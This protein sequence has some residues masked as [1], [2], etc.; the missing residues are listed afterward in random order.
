M[1]EIENYRRNEDILLAEL[2]RIRDMADARRSELLDQRLLTRL[3]ESGEVGVTARIIEAPTLPEGAVWPKP[4]LVLAG[5]AILGLMGGFFMALV[6]L[7]RS[8]GQWV[9]SS[10]AAGGKAKRA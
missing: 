5:G 3:A 4:I 10:K 7:R 1:A 2:G 6:S 9:A 8:R